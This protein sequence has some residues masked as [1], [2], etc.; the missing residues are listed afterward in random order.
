MQSTE[1]RLE[2]E[3]IERARRGDRA[4]YAVFAFVLVS[5]TGS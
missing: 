2:R 4:A 5:A 1:G 3:L